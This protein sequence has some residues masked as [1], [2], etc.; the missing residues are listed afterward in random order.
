MDALAVESGLVAGDH[1]WDEGLGEATE[2]D[3][4]GS[5]VDVEEV[6]HAMAR[7]VEVAQAVFP[8]E[9]TCQHVELRARGA[10]GEDG[11]GKGDV[12]LHHQGEVGALLRRRRAQRDGARDVGGAVEVLR[13]RVDEQQVAVA[14]GHV[15]LGRGLV[16]DDGAVGAVA[17]D[18]AERLV[19]EQRHGLAV[20]VENLAH[21]CLGEGFAL[22]GGTALNFDE[23]ARQRHAVT[24]HSGAYSAEL[25]VVLD[26][27]GHGDGRVGHDGAVTQG[28]HQRHGVACG[29]DKDGGVGGEGGGEVEHRVVGCRR[30]AVCRQVRRHLVGELGRVD[31]QR[32][33]FVAEV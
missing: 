31:E 19:K 9:L 7:A 5:L 10:R 21:A 27:L 30:Y 26:G 8:Q 4:L 33:P 28:V 25:H 11:R 17:G 14:H 18:G 3:A 2:G 16:V 23:A 32:R 15:T 24:G 20:A 12:T 22:A 6:A 1:A 29:F 13:A